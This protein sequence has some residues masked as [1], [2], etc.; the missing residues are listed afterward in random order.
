M[1]GSF[2][3]ILLI[4]A[5]PDDETYAAQTI[6]RA[7]E[8]GVQVYLHVLSHGE[9]GCLLSRGPNGEWIERRDVTANEVVTVRD[10]EMHAAAELLRLKYKHL[11]APELS[12]DFGFTQSVQATFDEWERRVPGGVKAI[13][14]RLAEEIRQVNPTIL[15]TLDPEDDPHGSG[16]G[17]HRALGELVAAALK[18]S[19]APVSELLTFA[20]RG[21]LADVEVP[22]DP[23]WRRAVLNAY[24][25]QFNVDAD[26]LALRQSEGFLVRY[27][28]PAEAAVGGSALL[29][30]LS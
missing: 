13:L 1:S 17:H 24:P 19:Q 20:P 23:A 12:L 30:M 2:G 25:S 11:Y 14:A 22:A 8:R 26:P 16:H 18:L 28:N 21:Q 4:T 6:A 27:R 15:M 5:H 10:Q 9:G 3:K 7:A 29:R